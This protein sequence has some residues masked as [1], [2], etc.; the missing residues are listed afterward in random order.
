MVGKEKE[1]EKEGGRAIS[2]PWR[3][4]KAKLYLHNITSDIEPRLFQ[5]SSAFS[6]VRKV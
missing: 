6:Y 3:Y 2:V 4:W 1:K 5:Y